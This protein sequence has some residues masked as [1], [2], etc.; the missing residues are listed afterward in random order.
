MQTDEVKK[1]MHATEGVNL[2][3]KN[4]T[5]QPF[6]TKTPILSDV[7]YIFEKGHMT[8]LLGPNG[9]GKTTMLRHFLAQIKC[10]RG[11]V[12]I[13]EKDSSSFPP[14]ERSRMLSWVPQYRRGRHP[15]G[16]IPV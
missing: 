14:K 13:G 8:A 10:P 15:D 2:Q 1:E 3:A 4:L 12:L 7:S 9:S 11:A 5:Y 16:T 6:G